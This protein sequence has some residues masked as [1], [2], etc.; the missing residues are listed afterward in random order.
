MNLSKDLRLNMLFG[1]FIGFLIGMNVLAAKIV[2]FGPFSVSVAFIIVPLTFLITDIVTEV[3]GKKKGREWV[4][5][6][7]FTLAVFLGLILLFVALPPAARFTHNA[8]YNTIFG[9]SARIIAA[10]ITAFLLSEFSD[11]WTFW[12]LREWT[13]KRF[14]WFRT[15][16]SNILSMTIDTFSFMYLAFYMLTPKFTALFVLQMIIPYLIFKI[17]WGFV[18]SP[19]VYAGARWLKGAGK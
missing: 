3:Y 11:V 13:K 4:I 15:N 10:S 17:I 5:A 18:S 9:T 7:V 12:L 8:E 2:P 6:G 14:L 16:I 19:L 1:L